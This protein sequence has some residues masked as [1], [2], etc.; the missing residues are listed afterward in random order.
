LSHNIYYVIL[1]FNN[2]TTVNYNN[3]S[4]ILYTYLSKTCYNYC[5]NNVTTNA[6][7]SDNSDDDDD[8]DDDVNNADDVV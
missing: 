3:K 4:D 2:I 5:L 7:T 8:A 6:T 1:Q